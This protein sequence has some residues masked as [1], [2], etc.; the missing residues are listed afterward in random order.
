MCLAQFAAFYYKDYKTEYDETKDSQP[1]ILNDELLESHNSTANTGQSL[2]SKIKLM[3]KNEYMKCRKVKAV[4]R[5]H[6]PK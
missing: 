4:I 5:Y 3:N 6:T 2:P 1:I